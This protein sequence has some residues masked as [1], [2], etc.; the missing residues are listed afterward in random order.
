[1]MMGG[2]AYV[3]SSTGYNSM[4]LV[5]GDG[6]IVVDVPPTIGENVN[7]AIAEVTNS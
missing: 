3:V 2:G 1:M 6:V 5:T 7:D 4:F